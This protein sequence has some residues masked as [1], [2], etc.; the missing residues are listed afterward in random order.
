M[1]RIIGTVLASGINENDYHNQNVKKAKKT[2]KKVEFDLS[3]NTH[4]IK[5]F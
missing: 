2:K 1:V 5:S 3:K 4:N